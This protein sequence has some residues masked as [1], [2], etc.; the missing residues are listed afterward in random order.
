M[1]ATYKHDHPSVKKGKGHDQVRAPSIRNNRPGTKLSKP[2]GFRDL[3]SPNAC[4]DEPLNH[5]HRPSTCTSTNSNPSKYS[6]AKSAPPS[7]TLSP[8]SSTHPRTP[9]PTNHF[10]STNGHRI[11]SGRP[12]LRRRTVCYWSGLIRT[13]SMRRWIACSFRIC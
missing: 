6:A 12:R 7:I 4:T 11:V 3:A 5:S 13:M 2:S 8:T 10:T 9:Q 1:R